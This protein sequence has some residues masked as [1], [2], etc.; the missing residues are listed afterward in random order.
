M[1]IDFFINT[2]KTNSNKNEFSVNL[3]TLT[4]KEEES[5]N[6]DIQFAEPKTYLKT[7]VEIRDKRFDSGL[8][9]PGPPALITDNGIFFIYNASNSGSSGDPDLKAGE[10]TVGQVLFD[11]NDPSAIIA[12]CDNYFLSSQN[13]NE[14]T[15]QMSN[16][17]FVEALVHF[18]NKWIIYYVTGEANI[19]VAFCDAIFD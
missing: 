13:P 14:V 16:T 15:G 9:E 17:A 18:K 19:G 7:A 11:I 10:Y 12:R 4:V 5:L 2:C 6:N 3:P 1:P 8:V